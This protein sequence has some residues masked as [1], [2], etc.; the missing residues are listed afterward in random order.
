MEIVKKGDYV[1][2]KT[3]SG[4]EKMGILD[5]TY[6]DGEHCV[7]EA[8]TNRRF[9]S[10]KNDVRKARQDEAEKIKLLLKESKVMVLKPKNHIQTTNEYENEFEEALAA[11]D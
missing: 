5:Y 1:I 10:H 11:I 7:I 2:A 4:I 9:C 6:T 3:W 8:S